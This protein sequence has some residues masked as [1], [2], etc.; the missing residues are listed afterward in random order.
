MASEY[1]VVPPAP[2]PDGPGNTYAAFLTAL[3]KD[4][5]PA[6]ICHYYN[7]YFAHTA[8]GRM[9]GAKVSQELFG[10]K[11]LAFYSYE[12][13]DVAPLLDAVRASIN[14]LAEAWTDAQK[15]RC[16]EETSAS[17][18]WSGQLLRL[19]TETA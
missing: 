19:I 10:G 9:I 8:G 17:F 18:K 16:L 5:A 11:E 2:A 6:F 15:A 3:A 4:D 7:F 14:A 13:G 1:G 12:G